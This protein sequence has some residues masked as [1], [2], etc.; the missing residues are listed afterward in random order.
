MAP[1]RVLVFSSLFPSVA[2]PRHGIFVETRLAQLRRE[3]EVDARVIAPVP[4]FPSTARVFGEYARFAATPRHA[5]RAGGVPVSHPRY[6]MLPRVGMASQPDSM[7]RAA[8]ADVRALQAEGW[9]PDII[10]AHYFYPD[11]VAAA[12]LAEQLG[13][14]FVITARGSD[15]NLIARLP[16]PRQRIVAAASRAAAVIAV[17]TPLK[18]ALVEL[19]VDEGKVVVL[20]NGVDTEVFRIEDQSASRQQL[21]LPLQGPLALCVGNL[22]PEK[23][24]ALA[25][26]ALQHQP[27]LHLA[28]VGEG[29]L[30][31]EL[32]QLAAKLG[33][34]ERV[35]FLSNMPQQQLR[36]AY[37]AADVL[38]L[39][40]T[41]EG[42]PNVVLESL[43]C[44]TPVVAADVGAV[45]EMLTVPQAGR[46][47]AERG[48]RQLANEIAALLAAPPG[49]DAVRRHACSFDWGSIARGQMEV[50]VR[51]IASHGK[52]Q[53]PAAWRSAAAG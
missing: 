53:V 21:A 36:H 43:A 26:E 31:H 37:A 1:P 19:G 27:A 52:V 32:E 12:W 2:R 18:Q 29:P 34:R 11:G 35:S 10:D 14:P 41:R 24:Q 17:S 9:A 44:G 28:V 16:G 30:R 23:G 39:T 15:I 4:W 47:L 22:L 38:L 3:C 49:R 7:A 6:L 50:F 51:A 33:V 13:V 8:L 5:Q 46:V 42:W 25:I 45:R 48:A 20:R 40:S